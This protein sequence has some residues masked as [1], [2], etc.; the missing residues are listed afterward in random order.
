MVRALSSAW[1][2]IRILPCIEGERAISCAFISR[3]HA[4]INLFPRRPTR[5][6]GDFGADDMEDYKNEERPEHKWEDRAPNVTT[7]WLVIVSVVLFAAAI[8]AVG[9]AYEQSA[10]VTALN[11]QNQGMR[12]VETQMR[13]Q[14]DTLRT[15]I[16]QM[17]AQQQQT[18]AASAVSTART[19]GVST[20]GKSTAK[21]SASAGSSSQDRRMKQIQSQIAEQKKLLKQTQDDIASARSDLEGKLGS[22][23]DELNGSIARTHDEL[24]GL[25]KRGER[26]YYEFDLSKSKGFQREGPIQISLRKADSKHQSYDVVMLVDD[27]QLSKKRVDLYEPIWLDRADQIGSY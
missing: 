11:Q 26:N 3:F 4:V 18:D 5:A 12:A 17:T 19:G 24:V 15:K 10:S 7:R 16:D 14:I 23:R 27:H 2:E 22:T 1:A 9:Y 13:G 25:E 20:S 8:L 6:A 21:R